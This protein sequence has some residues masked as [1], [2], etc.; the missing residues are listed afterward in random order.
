MSF[1]FEHGA[2]SSIAER[3]QKA[4]MTC[5]WEAKL[6]AC[7]PNPAGG[8]FAIRVLA[9]PRLPSRTVEVHHDS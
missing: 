1:C 5:Q 4:P 8:E 7:L 9:R 3:L 2:T 6:M